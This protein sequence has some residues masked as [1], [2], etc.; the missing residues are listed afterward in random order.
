MSALATTSAAPIGAAIQRWNAWGW[1]LAFGITLVLAWINAGPG[2]ATGACLA[3]LASWILMRNS[4]QPFSPNRITI[5]GFW[6]VTY[7]ML[8]FWPSF[9]VYSEQSDSSRQDYM[10]AVLSVVITV[11]AGSL[12]ASRLFFHGSDR[13][14][15]FFRAPVEGFEKTLGF[16]RAFYWLLGFALAMSVMYV[17]EVQ[18]IPL[19]YLFS[20]PGDALTLAIL[21]EESFKL[22]N[23]PFLYIYYVMRAVL[24]PFLIMVALGAYLATRQMKWL[25]WSVLAGITGIVFAAM[26]LAKGPVATIILMASLFFYYYRHGKLSRRFVAGS[27]ILIFLFPVLVVLSVY[28]GANLTWEQ[29]GPSMVAIGDRIFHVPAQMVYYY[30]EFFPRQ[31]GYLHGRSINMLSVLLGMKHVDTPNVVGLYAFPYALGSISA[32]A[33]FI[34]DLHADFGFWGVMIGGVLAG[35]VMQSLHIYLV[36]RRK[37]IATLACYAF[38]VVTFCFLHATS[39]TQLLVSNGALLV[40]LLALVFDR[41]VSVATRND[42]G[43]PSGAARASDGAH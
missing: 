43:V 17:S 41:S 38:L 25:W 14:E 7:L 18:T 42:R 23:S 33:A 6:F 10:I 24:Y 5:V 4:Y 30:F 40:L 20:H 36:C 11:P 13:T 31:M 34:A 32:N 1:L 12:L 8:I 37:T 21:R 15:K 2:V 39:L 28:S 3:L 16:G 27:L 29:L 35:L 26:T 22:L 9:Q 19:V